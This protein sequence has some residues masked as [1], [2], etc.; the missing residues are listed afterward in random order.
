MI[1][2]SKPATRVPIG[3]DQGA[4]KCS[5]TTAYTACDLPMVAVHEITH[6]VRRVYG[7]KLRDKLAASCARSTEWLG[8]MANPST[9]TPAS[10]FV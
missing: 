1:S 7:L 2:K 3:H 10:G 6:A 8:I 9:T 5:C 4:A